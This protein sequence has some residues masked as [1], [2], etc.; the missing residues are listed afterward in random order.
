[1]YS[2]VMLVS[3]LVV[4]LASLLARLCPASADNVESRASQ[5]VAAR[6]GEDQTL[7]RVFALESAA[8]ALVHQ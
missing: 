6:Q 5:R 8:H 4:V 2:R 7:A 3:F 1:M